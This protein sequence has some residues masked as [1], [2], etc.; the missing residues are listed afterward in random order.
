MKTTNEIKVKANK[1]A[2]TFTIRTSY[3]KYRTIRLSKDEFNNSLYN[4]TNDWLNFL[5]SS[6]YTLVK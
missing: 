1:S 2:R 6:D 3:A 5:K 4:T